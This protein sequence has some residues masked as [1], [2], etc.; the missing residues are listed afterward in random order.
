ME[1][2]TVW[3]TSAQGRPRS[4]RARHAI[5]KAAIEL[6]NEHGVAMVSVEAIAS[7]A[8]VS[9][10]TIYRWWPNKASVVTDGFLEL[11]APE[12]LFSIDTGSVKQDILSQ[13]RELAKLFVGR[14]GQIIS[15]LMAEA[16]ADPDVRAALLSRWV[17]ARRD[18]VGEL[19][20]RGM[21]SGELR[22]DLDLDVAMDALFG[23]IYY[24]LLMGHLPLEQS[25]V[26]SL[27]NHVVSGLAP[28]NE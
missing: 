1:K 8:G 13:M 19:L 26:D 15:G 25:F 17:F 6:V 11:I 5:L 9:K 24:R 28:R 14:N 21:E 23:P 7:R 16:Q 2:Q 4:E 22:S 12:T 18:A 3:K 10:A 20:Q 27:A